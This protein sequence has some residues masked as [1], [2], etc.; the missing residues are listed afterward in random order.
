MQS[1]GYIRSLPCITIDSKKLKYN[2]EAIQ[3]L[4]VEHKLKAHYAT[5]GICA[6]E[7]ITKIMAEVGIRDF[8]D[9]NLD[10]LVKVKPYAESTILTRLPMLSESREIVN[11][12]DISFNSELET[13]FALSDAAVVEH[14]KHGVILLVELGDLGPGILPDDL[15]S[16]VHQVLNLRGVKLMGIATSLNTFSGIIPTIDK[17]QEFAELANQIQSRF[18]IELEYISGGN[19]GTIHF[20]SSEDFPQEINHL[21]VGEAWLLGQETSYGH[22]ISNLH[23]DIFN[24]SCEVIENKRKPSKPYGISGKNYRGQRVEFADRGIIRRV[25][26]NIGRQDIDFDGIKLHEKG[27]EHIGSALEYS[28]FDISGYNRDIEIGGQIDFSMNYSALNSAF[29]STYVKKVLV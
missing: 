4:F 9:S 18:G 12:V 26:L 8:A 24:L 19:S 17:M 20:I 21:T 23:Q 10:N 2:L 3:K 15:L 13:I 25:I 27:I 28:V 29:A 22:R 11:K 7:P 6:F 14:K 16:T 1:K 5:Q